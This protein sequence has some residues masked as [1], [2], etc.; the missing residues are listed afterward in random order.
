MSTQQ[1]SSRYD[2]VNNRSV[3]RRINH[4][5]KR[6]SLKYDLSR[7]DRQDI[8]QEFYLALVRAG[9]SYDPAKCPPGRFVL[10]VINRYYKHFVRKLNRARQN[11]SRSVDAI[12]FADL[13]PSFEYK[14][15]DP[16]AQRSLRSIEMREDTRTLIEK[17]P[18][19]LRAISLELMSKTPLEVARRRGVHHSTVYRALEKIRE[20]FA[21]YE[22]EGLFQF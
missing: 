2:F 3:A 5:I 17:L 11:R 22:I 4:R 12:R 7:E 20:C 1:D 14:I 16:K 18:K 8:R 21:N 9:R 10:M 13:N 19:E 15:V 6:L